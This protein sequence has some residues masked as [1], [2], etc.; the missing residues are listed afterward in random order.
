IPIRLFSIGGEKV[1]PTRQHV[2][3]HV[4]HDDANAVRLFVERDEVFFVLQLR[5]S[6]VG[7]FLVSTKARERVIEIM[8][9]KRG[10]SHHF[11]HSVS[12]RIKRS[13]NI[14]EPTPKLPFGTTSCVFVD[15]FP[16]VPYW[17]RAETITEAALL[18]S[19]LCCSPVPMFLIATSPFSFSASP[20]MATNGRPFDAAYLNCLASLSASGYNSTRTPCERNSAATAN[21]S[22]IVASLQIA[23][24]TSAA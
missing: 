12:N 17:P 6:F 14:H 2:A 19:T 24:I 22:A 4:F 13:T 1:S 9:S 3:G 7:Q 8:L 23:T 10:L 20:M 5:Q 21:E 15:S 18:R 16:V 11:V